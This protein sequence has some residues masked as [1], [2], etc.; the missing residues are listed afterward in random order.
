MESS[1]IRGMETKP[2]ALKIETV[3]VADLVADP[4]NIRKHDARTCYAIECDPQYCDHILARWELEAGA[5][6]TL[7]RVIE[8]KP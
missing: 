8:C 1:T 3:R 6:A 7:E 5:S 2:L 4:R